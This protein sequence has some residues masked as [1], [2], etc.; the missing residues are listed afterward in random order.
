LSRDSSV[1]IETGYG[2]DGQGSILGKGKKF[3]LLHTVEAGSGAPPSLLPI[4]AGAYSP[5][6]KSRS[7]KLTTHSH[8]VQRLRMVELYLHSPICIHGVVLN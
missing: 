3:S 7:V 4:G 2:L 5:G 1:V 6:L 8:I